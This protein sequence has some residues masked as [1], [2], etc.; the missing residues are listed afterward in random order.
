M[1]ASSQTSA[2]LPAEHPMAP[3]IVTR[4][5]SVAADG[6]PASFLDAAKPEARLEQRV[7]E[8]EQELKK[9][10]QSEKQQKQAD[11]EDPTVRFA[12][13]L[14]ADALYF[15]Q[16]EANMDTVGDIHDGAAD[17]V[18]RRYAAHTGPPSSALRIGS[19]RCA[20][21]ILR[22]MGIHLRPG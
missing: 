14:Q 7:A 9:S 8:L 10:K 20:R 6:V 16:D 2:S 15:G 18:P 3:P 5:P 21:A 4:L 19:G 13:Q 22:A 1:L 12:M 11:A 17:A